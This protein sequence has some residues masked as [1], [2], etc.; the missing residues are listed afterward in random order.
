MVKTAD[1]YDR[2]A[3]A[4]PEYLVFLRRGDDWYEVYGDTAEVFSE[5]LTEEVQSGYSDSRFV[6]AW[7]SH[8]HQRV[9]GKVC[10]LHKDV[11]VFEVPLLTNIGG[12]RN[13]S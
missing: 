8:R 1:H 9:L 4:Y 13:D 7:P 6:V 12:P 10:A 5:Y 2:L 11:L 3:A